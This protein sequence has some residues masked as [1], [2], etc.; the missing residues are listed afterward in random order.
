MLPHIQTSLRFSESGGRG[1]THDRLKIAVLAPIPSDSAI[2]TTA[3][4]P[5]Q[6]R[7]QSVADV[8]NDCFHN[9]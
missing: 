2:R 6:R 1:S 7:T 3:V 9:F 5:G 8:S 4:K